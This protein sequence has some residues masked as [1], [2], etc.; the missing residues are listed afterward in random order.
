MFNHKKQ[1]RTRKV[2]VGT[3][4]KSKTTIASRSL[5]RNENQPRAGTPTYRAW[6]VPRYPSLRHVPPFKAAACFM[7]KFHLFWRNLDS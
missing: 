4:K 2:T 1:Y 6:K 3:V 7:S 5:A